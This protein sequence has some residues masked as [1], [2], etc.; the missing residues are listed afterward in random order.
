MVRSSTTEITLASAGSPERSELG[1]RRF[2]LGGIGREGTSGGR[3]RG[4]PP[5]A[6]PARA[7]PAAGG[8]G[9]AG[10]PCGDWAVRWLCMARLRP[11]TAMTS[12]MARATAPVMAAGPG[13][14]ARLAQPTEPSICSSMSRLHST[15]YSIGSVRVTGSMKPLTIMLMACCSDRPRLIR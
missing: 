11:A 12:T 13:T 15:A 10:A 1:P 6:G 9:V 5:V 7:G 3:R 2:G 4:G 8:A 14:P